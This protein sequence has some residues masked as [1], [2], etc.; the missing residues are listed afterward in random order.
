MNRVL[1]VLTVVVL[2][3]ASERA[4][5]NQ[6]QADA[7]HKSFLVG[8]L[9]TPDDDP[10]FYMR[11]TVVDAQSGAGNDGL[12]TQSDAQPT[13]RVRWEIA[14]DILVARLT[15]ELIEGTDGHGTRRTADG[16]IVAAYPITKHFDIRRE[17]NPTTGE[18][19]NVL[20]ENETD[21][22]W[23]QR[24]YLRVDWSRNLVQS[25]YELDTMAQLGIWYGVAWE[26]VSYY[27][28]D[29]SHPD[30]PVF[31]V[32][33]GYFDVTNK[34]WATPET[35]EDEW[36]GTTPVCWLLG[37]YPATSCSPSEVTMRLSFKRVTDTDY[38]ALQ[39][40][41]ERM[42]LFGLFDYNRF[43]YDRRYGVTDQKW[44]RL[45]ARWNIWQRSHVDVPCNT[46][47]TTPFGADPH[48]D[49]EPANGT[50]DECE[51]VGRG[52][53]CDDFAG[54]CTIPYRD[55][56]LRTIAWHVNQGFD[57]TLFD[58]TKEA[59]DAWSDAARVAVLAARM[60]ECRRTGEQG[61]EA[62]FG[63]PVPWT[64][65]YVPPVG[66]A[67]P[68]EVPPVFVLCHN[69]VDP[70]KGDDEA[71]CGAAGTSPR[72]GD[73]RYNIAAVIDPMQVTSPWGI[74]MDAE[75]PLT[76][77]KISGS[78]NVWGAVTDRHA[79][80][81]VDLLSLLNGQIDAQSF[82]EGENIALWIEKQRAGGED[83]MAGR[84]MPAAELE[85]RRA[86]FDPQALAS[87]Y[88]GMPAHTQHAHP[89][90]RHQARAQALI[91]QGKLGPGNAAL[92]AR[93]RKLQ[94]SEV[95]AMLVSPHMAQLAGADPTVT[96]SAETIRRASPFGRNNPAARRDLERRLRLGA[97][98]RHACRLEAPDPDSLT[99]L[100][101]VAQELFPAPDPN[102]PV[103]VNDHRQAVYLWARQSF[104]RGV[105]AHELGHSMGL[106]HNFAASWDSLNYDARYWQLRTHNDEVTADCPDGNGDGSDC[107]APRWRDPITQE[108]LDGNIGRFATTSV[109]DYPG[110]Q[111]QDMLLPGKYDRAAMRFAYGNTVDVWHEDGLSVN[112]GSARQD[113]AYELTAFGVTPGLFGVYYFPPITPGDFYEFIHYSRYP[114]RFD[115]LRNCQASDDPEAVLGTHCDEKPMD[116]VDFRDMSDFIDDPDYASFDWAWTAR[117]VD[118]AGRVRRGYAFS[119]DEYADAGNVP[120]FTDDAGAD[121][122]EQVRFL[123]SQY[124]NRYILDSFRRNRVTFNSEDVVWRVQ[125][126]YLDNIQQIAKTFAFAA[127]LD[128][129][130]ANPLPEFFD[131]GYY[132]PLGL[133]GTLAFDLYARQLTRPE[134]GY[135]CPADICG[136]LPYG[137]DAP[138]FA[139]DPYE[140][141]ELYIYDFHVS[142]GDGRYVH[143]DYDYSQGYWWGDYQTKVGAYYDKVWAIYYLAEAYDYFISNAKEDFTDS[144]YKNVNFA[145]VFPAQVRRLYGALMTGDWDSFAP[146]AVPRVDP[147]DT[148]E[149]LINYPLWHD[150]IDVGKRPQAALLADPNYAWNE[151][152]YAMVWGTVFFPTNWSYDF[153]HDAQIVTTLAEVPW[154][155][156]EVLE[157]FDPQSGITYRARADGLE[158]SPGGFRQRAVGARMLEWA[159]RLLA[160]AYLVE[161]DVNGDVVLDPSGKPILVL[162]VDGDPQLDPANPG[163]DAVLAKYVDNIDMMRQLVKTFAQPLGDDDLPQP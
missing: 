36:W 152:I 14:E 147:D 102:D 12:F 119:S 16:Q 89:K 97:A 65:A 98:R 30:H 142:L 154:P 155:A 83:A 62:T 11:V 149:V 125:A 156:D 136:T 67:A 3:C 159:N 55:R 115:L 42:D 61:C 146:W 86:A 21:R 150:S 56:A 114:E 18:E 35:Y 153:V 82:I 131:D 124:E 112:E 160:I 31:D 74:M 111:S 57:E 76:G 132:G 100:A 72:L 127:V 129:D 29:P 105:M 24:E 139:A 59:V 7:L 91:E 19:L 106:R 95:E 40:D 80:S 9:A 34:A 33:S 37:Y 69:P 81:L 60:T 22:P 122:Y 63:W 120:A 161:R 25:G 38:E 143:N 8:D 79:A 96:P 10:E 66:G 48:R 87:F 92:G 50:E 2:G 78:A 32:A 90:A 28:N 53:R 43:G 135:Y 108:E 13:M 109:M 101:L 117:V 64:D 17:Y 148:P 88:A 157:F 44:R 20:V 45:A 26:S 133:A 107:I 138:T 144:R 158:D 121:A 84:P 54:L 134:P 123:E 4:P 77:E 75:D 52:S 27:V 46:E 68:N 140:M 70:A 1:L 58:G 51:I 151:Q 5:I 15:Y 163:A 130:P 103:A 118:P 145:T 99:G 104:N 85:S 113:E 94:G 49:I 71:V 162:D 6:V 73:L 126:R 141:P 137:V 110:D 47:E 41:G 116:V 39:Y 128:G 93:M 23:Y